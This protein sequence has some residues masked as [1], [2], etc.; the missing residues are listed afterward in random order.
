MRIFIIIFIISVFLLTGCVNLEDYVP[1]EKYDS[2]ILELE[3]ANSNINSQNINIAELEDD[4]DLTKKELEQYRNLINSL[5]D[6]LKNV[7]YVYGSKNDGSSSCGTG[8]S[9]EYKGKNYLITAGHVVD[10]E[11]GKFEKTKWKAN[12][13]DE[14][15]YPEL[16]T[17]KNKL[18]GGNDY[19]IFYT[20]KIDNG[21]KIGGYTKEKFI[22]GN[23]EKGL[24]VFKEL[25]TSAIPGESGSPIINPE[26]WI[27]GIFTGF[28]TPIEIVTEAIDNLE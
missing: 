6:L 1:V 8:F 7:Y 20:D 17:C 2:K 27:I 5:N 4:L 25:Y 21:L 19:A 26:G 3:E 12:F 24:N 13:S 9:L 18:T 28:F 14:W 15:I 23:T 11:Y 10:N 16:L 22:L